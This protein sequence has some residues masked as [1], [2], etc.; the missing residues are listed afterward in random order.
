MSF[1][2]LLSRDMFT[3]ILWD[4]FYQTRAMHPMHWRGES[5]M[6]TQ[7]DWGSLIEVAGLLSLTHKPVPF[8]DTRQNL[9]FKQRT[10][11][12]LICHVNEWQFCQGQML[13]NGTRVFSVVL[14][15]P[16]EVMKTKN[17][18]GWVI[19]KPLIVIIQACAERVVDIHR[20]YSLKGML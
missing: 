17:R 19:M 12:D 10:F 15:I 7:N 14:C 13:L 8:P 16:Y 11:Y 18:F 9:I 1:D 6:S 5:N 4:G 2:I 20:R 3:Y